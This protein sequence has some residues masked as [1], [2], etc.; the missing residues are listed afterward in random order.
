MMY[1]FQFEP[2]ATGTTLRLVGPSGPLQ[3]DAWSL[4]A[5]LDLLPGVDL[6]RKLVES[7]AALADAEAVL[8]GHAAIAGLSAREAAF[9]KLP[10][11]ADVVA[12]VEAEGVIARAD[13]QVSLSWQRQNGQT[14]IGASRSGAWLKIGDGFRRLP[15]ALFALAE[16]VERVNSAPPDDLA[17]RFKALAELKEALPSAAEGGLVNAHGTLAATTISVADAFSLDT[18]GEG[19]DLRVVPVL[20]RLGGS[21]DDRLLSPEDQRAF[22]ERQFFCPARRQVRLCARWPTLRRVAA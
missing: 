2:S 22:G 6:V 11:L 3:F 5:P 9:F 4:D 12:R 15:D 16:A 17:G 14:I 1:R 19:A 8:V 21:P 13:Y 20:H 10:P 7:D 18:V